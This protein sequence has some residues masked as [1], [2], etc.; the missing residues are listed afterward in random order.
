MKSLA[1]FKGLSQMLVLNLLIKPAWIFFIDREVQNQV[2]HEVYGRYFAVF[3]L[4]YVLLFLTDAGLTNMVNQRIASH[5]PADPSHYWK[6]KLFFSFI[7]VAIAGLAGWITG[8]QQWSIFFYLISIQLLSSF[9][10]FFRSIITAHQFFTADAWLSVVDKFLMI[11]LCAGFIYAPVVFGK[12]TLWLFLKIQLLC[13]AF[14]VL[15]SFLFVVR[16]QLLT[17]GIRE[18][19]FSVVKSIAP[20]AVIILLMSMHYRIDGF[21]L[22]RIHSNGAYEAGIYASAYRLLDATNTVGYLAASFLVPFI[23]RHRFQKKTIQE[24]VINTR[25]GLLF[26]GIGV[27][28]FSIL[29]APWI[30]ELLYH[31]DTPYHSKV[32]QLCVAALPAYLLVHV[33]GSAL[34]AI[35]R[36]K[37]F[38]LILLISVLLNLVLNFILIPLYGAVGCCISALTSHYFCALG[39]YLVATK[40]LELPFMPKSII[41]YLAT[42][43]GLIAFFYFGKLLKLSVWLILVTAICFVLMLLIAQIT[44]NKKYFIRL[45]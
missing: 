40:S 18:N 37:S 23:A 4:S 7:Y 41:I 12:I 24:A 14:A 6:L 43:I 38:I 13:T 11:L 35:A 19:T 42:T 10:V 25:H 45:P 8:L 22:E 29:F 33:Y 3:N 34:T 20:F 36:Y 26:F 21:L 28:C 5:Q 1:F 27:A 30:Q 2:G 17:G 16:K 39:C 9:F 32:I 31:T 15:V 44:Y